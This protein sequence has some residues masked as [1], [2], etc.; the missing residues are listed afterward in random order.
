MKCFLVE[1]KVERLERLESRILSPSKA[2]GIKIGGREGQLRVNG[3]L[4]DC[5]CDHLETHRDGPVG[6]GTTEPAKPYRG[7]LSQSTQDD[8]FQY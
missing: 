4:C 6:G 7:E 8:H 5:I 1:N 2:T 3:L